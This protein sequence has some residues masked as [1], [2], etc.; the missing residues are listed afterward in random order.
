[1]SGLSASVKSIE[2]YLHHGC[3][4]LP[5]F[6]DYGADTQP[7]PSA[8]VKSVA[9][10]LHHGCGGLQDFTDYGASTSPSLRLREIL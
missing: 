3:G 1:M 2:E 10:R 7:F 8:S 5:D 4:G 6:T 9:E